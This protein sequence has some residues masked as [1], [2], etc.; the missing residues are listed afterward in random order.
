MET[1]RCRWRWRP[2][3]GRCPGRRCQTRPCG[4][5]ELSSRP[6]LALACASCHLC[7]MIERRIS[8]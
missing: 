1:S 8:C 6:L 4:E 7:F 5:L 3:A 2:A